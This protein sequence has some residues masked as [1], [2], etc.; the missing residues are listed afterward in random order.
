MKVFQVQ[1][2]YEA[3]GEIRKETM[4]VT[5]EDDDI[6]SVTEHFK[7]HCYEYEKDLKGIMEVLTVVESVKSSEN[8]PEKPYLE[9]EADRVINI[10]MDEFLSKS[11]ELM[12][13]QGYV[14]YHVLLKAIESL[15]EQ[16]K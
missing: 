16:D 13:P 12:D 11:L 5:A 3:D 2:E 4:F 8:D 7:R 14:S 15:K 6:L 10:C 9:D 1:T